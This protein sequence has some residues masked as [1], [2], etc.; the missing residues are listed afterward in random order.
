MGLYLIAIIVFLTGCGARLKNEYSVGGDASIKIEIV[1]KFPDAVLC[2]EALEKG[3]LTQE[4]FLIC[5]EELTE[6]SYTVG[7]DGEITE[8]LDGLGDDIT[9]KLTDKVDGSL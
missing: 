3:I 6:G 8:V 4:N 7:L 2:F 9:N 5:L 1:T